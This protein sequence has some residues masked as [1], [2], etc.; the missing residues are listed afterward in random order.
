MTQAQ[1][2]RLQNDST[3]LEVFANKMKEEGNLELVEKI[4][5]KKH[6]VDQHLQKY[7]EKAA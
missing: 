6:H 7:T 4:R 2:E 3:A 5:A 1:I